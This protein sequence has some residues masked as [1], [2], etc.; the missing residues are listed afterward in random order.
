MERLPNVERLCKEIMKS[1]NPYGVM[2]ALAFLLDATGTVDKFEK[3]TPVE[4]AQAAQVIK[5]RGRDLN[6][7]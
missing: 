2:N 5:G 1:K 6:E 3:I 7:R 4:V